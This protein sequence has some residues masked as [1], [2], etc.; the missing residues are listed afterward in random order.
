M[1]NTWILV[2]NASVAKLYSFSPSDSPKHKPKLTV[3]KEFQHPDSRKQDV[4]LVTDRPGDY[5]SKGGG[6]SGSFSQQTDPHQHE[7]EV[8]ARELAHL[9]EKARA[10]QQ[11]QALILVAG[12]HF[13]GLLRGCIDEHPLKHSPITEVQKDYTR[14]KPDQLLDLLDLIR[15]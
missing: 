4:D 6:G 9:L 13:M 1:D 11:F 2:A 5:K 10:G 12:P 3:V 15:K 14:E 8:F 7:A